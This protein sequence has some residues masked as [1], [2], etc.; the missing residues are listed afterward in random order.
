METK[1]KR[2]LLYVLSCV[3]FSGVLALSSC[4]GKLQKAPDIESAKQ[5]FE[6]FVQNMQSGNA[7]E[8]VRTRCRGRLKETLQKTLAFIDMTGEKPQ[9]YKTY[10]G[11]IKAELLPDYSDVALL[12]VDMGDGGGPMSFVLHFDASEE[13]KLY[14]GESSDMTLVKGFITDEHLMEWG[15]FTVTDSEVEDYLKD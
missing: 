2:V 12:L 5:A 7:Q 10:K 1:G 15:I 13:W 11:I 14:Y 4:N 3:L 8:A 9:F 6:A